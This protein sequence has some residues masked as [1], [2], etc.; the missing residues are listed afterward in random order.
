MVEITDA[1]IDV[2]GTRQTTQISVTTQTP[3]YEA[4]L[5][6][7]QD[8]LKKSAE[9]QLMVAAYY[10]N[11]ILESNNFTNNT[12]FTA[13]NYDED[14]ITINRGGTDIEL[15]LAR[16]L[17][18]DTKSG[19]IPLVQSYLAQKRVIDEAI[20]SRTGTANAI[21]DGGQSYSLKSKKKMKKT[22]RRG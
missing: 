4:K 20:N 16:T 2:L 10:N 3:G 22:S 18:I 6:K 7:I 13:L 5:R 11:L 21:M 19:Q 1:Q 9:I 12:D 15:T 14:T 8:I 17:N